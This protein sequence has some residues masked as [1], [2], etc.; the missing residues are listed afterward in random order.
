MKTNYIYYFI[1][2]KN[3]NKLLFKY[4]NIYMSYLLQ[5]TTY[6]H[7]FGMGW[8]T[9]CTSCEQDL[10]NILIISFGILL[11]ICLSF[12]VAINLF[13]VILKETF[14]IFTFNTLKTTRRA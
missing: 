1:S 14:I 5:S 10:S 8:V 7:E 3:C 11:C 13:E 2:Y 4:V 9:R 6:N 12:V